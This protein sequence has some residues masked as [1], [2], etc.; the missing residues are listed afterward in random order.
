MSWSNGYLLSF[1]IG[2]CRTKFSA[3][4]PARLNEIFRGFAQS[5]HENASI[6]DNF[7]LLVCVKLVSLL[8]ISIAYSTFVFEVN[9]Y[10]TEGITENCSNYFY[11]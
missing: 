10:K 7:H 5:L 2:R 1:V 4:L 6:W 8:L 11:F 3:S 9:E